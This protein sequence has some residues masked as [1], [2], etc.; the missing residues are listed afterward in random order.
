MN[1]MLYV[2]VWTW[3]DICVA[4]D[5]VSRVYDVWLMSSRRECQAI[6]KRQVCTTGRDYRHVWG[7]LGDIEWRRWV[8]RLCAGGPRE[9]IGRWRY[10][11]AR[12]KYRSTS[13]A[14]LGVLMQDWRYVSVWELI[15]NFCLKCLYAYLLRRELS[16]AAGRCRLGG[17]LAEVSKWSIGAYIARSKAIPRRNQLS[18]HGWWFEIQLPESL[19]GGMI[20]GGGPEIC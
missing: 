5:G 6:A 20:F 7:A 18:R 17:Q 19:Q 12:G 16:A 14:F 9:L 15:C 4:R 2:T 10:I 1:V 8:V 13:G 11:A 3:D